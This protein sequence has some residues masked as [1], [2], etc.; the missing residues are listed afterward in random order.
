MKSTQT[1]AYWCSMKSIMQRLEKQ[2][3][4]SMGDRGF[5]SI[6]SVMMIMGILTLLTIGFTNIV[7][8]AQ[9]S[10]LDNQLSTQ[11]F[12][13]A[14]SG[15]NDA[16]RTLQGNSDYSKTT[17]EGDTTNFT[18][19]IN[20]AQNVHYTCILV[21][22]TPP[23]LTYDEVP[24]AGVGEPILAPL[25]SA[26]GA[27]IDEIQFS[28]DAPNGTDPIR[29]DGYAGTNPIFTTAAAWGTYVGVMRVDLI[30]MN[31]TYDRASLVNNSYTFFLYPSLNG[32]VVPMT[33]T[34][35]NANQ[36]PVLE[37]DCNAGAA[38]RC[39][40]NI[41]LQHTSG[42]LT[43]NNYRMRIQSLY[44]PVRVHSIRILN[45]GNVLDLENGQAV[46]DSTGR[47]NDV[48]RRIQVRVPLTI[49]PGMHEPFSILSGDSICKRLVAAGGAAPTATT[50][51]LNATDQAC[52][53]PL[54]P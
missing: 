48:F 31:I 24:V 42:V 27:I 40:A 39:S 17:C 25:E 52:Q 11:A 19:V 10:T 21:D 32:T 35:G 26:N 13:A 4:N 1:R 18:Y 51:A 36:G 50:D 54:T 16:I 3:Q 15:V 7:R 6:F 8:R 49:V 44:Q 20:A 12:Y 34:N 5:V 28:F 41:Q 9:R 29:N 53:I 37:V 38:P 14:E 30:P 43:A 22:S 47:A 2:P 23:Y 33:V 46:I 45:S